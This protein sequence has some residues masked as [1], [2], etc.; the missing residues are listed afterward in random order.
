MKTIFK[1]PSTLLISIL[2]VLIDVNSF[3][4]INYNTFNY[5]LTN[6]NYSH[7][8]YF[9]EESLDLVDSIEILLIG[10]DG[11]P[12]DSYFFLEIKYELNDS[13]NFELIPPNL[14]DKSKYYFKKEK[15]TNSFRVKN[16]DNWCFIT[17]QTKRIILIVE[18]Y[19][20]NYLISS[21]RELSELELLEIRNDIQ[22]NRTPKLVLQ[23]VCIVT[24]QL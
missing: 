7:G 11:K 22:H 4:Q 24:N 19:E 3:A 1:K 9:L 8:Y 16:T 17:P 13:V 21:I 2:L 23:E 5:R 10:M 6:I 12:S 20:H 15:R 18:K 14:D